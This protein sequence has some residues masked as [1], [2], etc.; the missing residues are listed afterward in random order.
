[1]VVDIGSN[2]NNIN[3]FGDNFYE[4][5]YSLIWKFGFEE[6]FKNKRQNLAKKL[7]KISEK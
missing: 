3:Y 4:N 7:V 2:T 5:W 6:N 1:M